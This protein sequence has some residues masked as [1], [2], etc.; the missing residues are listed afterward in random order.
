M[1]F[2]NPVMNREYFR[3]FQVQF[4]RRRE[5]KTD[6]FARRRLIVQDKNKYETPK[7]R[8]VVRRT[9]KDIICQIVYS[10]IQGDFVLCA[11]YAHELPRFGLKVGLTNYSAAYCTG[12]LLARRVLKQLGLD[13]EYQGVT[14]V[15]GKMF[16]VE[17]EGDRN[18]FRCYL[19]VGLVRTTTANRVFGALKGA[20]DGGLDIPHGSGRFAGNIDGRYNAA[21]HRDR[22]MGDHVAEYMNELKEED[23]EAFNKQFSRYIKEGITADDIEGMYERVHAAIR[24][25]PDAA[26]KK[27]HTKPDKT[28]GRRNKMSLE[29]R[30][31]RIRQKKESRAYKL[32][33]ELQE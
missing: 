14:E 33:Q 9:N 12:L 23:E 28:F 13:S 31:D 11:A 3:S 30:K 6:Y 32:M 16:H 15:T 27:E 22:I 18:P 10:K 7:Y 26:A 17:A 5:G 19:D 4:R 8:L 21:A 25:N 24:T 1:P 2:H 29:Q 20:V